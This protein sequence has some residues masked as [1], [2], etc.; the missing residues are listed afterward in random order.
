MW[1]LGVILYTLVSGSLPFDGSTLRELRERVLRGK[2]RIPF[3]MSTD[4]ENLLKRFLV[5]NPARRASLD[6]I[7]KDKWMNMGYEDDELLPFKEPVLDIGDQKRVDVLVTMGYSR[8]DAEE[9]LRMHK[10][11]DAYATY[12]LLGRRTVEASFIA[13]TSLMAR[14]YIHCST[15]TQVDSDGSRS[16][17]SLSLR[18]I[19]PSGGGGMPSLPSA[20]GQ[21]SAS[22]SAAAAPTAAPSAST[23]SSGAAAAA[24]ADSVAS[25]LA[26]AAT[27]GSHRGVHRSV[28]VSSS[29][30]QRRGSSTGAEAESFESAEMAVAAAQPQSEQSHGDSQVLRRQS[31]AAAMGEPILRSRALEAGENGLVPDSAW[32]ETAKAT[33]SNC[34]WISFHRP[35]LQITPL[36]LIT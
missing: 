17:S 33:Y 29:G 22:T 1:S 14:K 9:S 36:A 12:L 10:F 25:S 34:N 7:M 18:N 23:S 28:S 21:S 13:V 2:Y 5:L 19:P 8:M 32:N 4:C 15:L 11:D 20:P 35:Y 24:A 16:G 30:K 3:Y 26:P 27:G 31:M 6:A